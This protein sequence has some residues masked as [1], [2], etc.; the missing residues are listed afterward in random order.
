MKKV[1]ISMLGI[2]FQRVTCRLVDCYVTLNVGGKKT[3]SVSI[4]NNSRTLPHL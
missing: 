2:A 1:V 4:S 3:S